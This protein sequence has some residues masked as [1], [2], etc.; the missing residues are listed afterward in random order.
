MTESGF[1]YNTY[2]TLYMQ[3]HVFELSTLFNLFINQELKAFFLNIHL[4]VNK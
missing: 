3:S 1:M 4:C 2:I